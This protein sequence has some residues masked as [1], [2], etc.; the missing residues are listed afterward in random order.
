M[1]RHA[2][3]SSSS[4]EIA[5]SSFLSFVIAEEPY[6]GL[7]TS[8]IEKAAESLSD[9]CGQISSKDITKVIFSH[10]SEE[11]SESAL[12]D[13]PMNLF[14]DFYVLDWAVDWGYGEADDGSCEGY[15][16][17][18]EFLLLVRALVKPFE[19]KLLCPFIDKELWANNKGKAKKEAWRTAVE[20][21]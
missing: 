11:E 17:E 20:S 1:I 6:E 8:I 12:S 18:G 7:I 5:K 9:N 19:E 21:F 2:C 13:L 4:Q 14:L 3:Q 16:R 15:L 10:F